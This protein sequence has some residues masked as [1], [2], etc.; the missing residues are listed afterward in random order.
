MHN[1]E[2]FVSLAKQL[3]A[4]G[5]D[6]IC[7]KDM[8]NLLL[9]MDAYS[10]VPKLKA[11]VKVPI[12]LHTHN[13]TATGDMVNLM[14][15]YAGV[16]IVDCALSPLANG[17]SQPATESLV[18]TLAGHRPGTP[19]WIWARCPRLRPTSAPSPPGSRPPALSIRRS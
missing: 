19:A 18:A 9:P 6:S 14:A 17:T 4:M 13:T 11:A 7:I 2:Y 15:A 12:H 16:D 5:A 8:A 1:E 10:L 3:E